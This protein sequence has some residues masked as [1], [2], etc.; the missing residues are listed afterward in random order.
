MRC[1]IGRGGKQIEEEEMGKKG[2][3]MGRRGVWE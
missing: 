1:K 2:E 3:W